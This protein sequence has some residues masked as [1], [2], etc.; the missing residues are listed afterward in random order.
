M[1]SV[2]FKVNSKIREHIVIGIL[3]YIF[4]LYVVVKPL[5]IVFLKVLINAFNK[6]IGV[7]QRVS[8]QPG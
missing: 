8:A 4:S 6:R 3:Y 1:R 7:L 5:G 2:S